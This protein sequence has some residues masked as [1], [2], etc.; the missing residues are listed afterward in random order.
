MGFRSEEEVE[1]AVRGWL[2]RTEKA[3]DPDFDMLVEADLEDR[4]KS[5]VGLPATSRGYHGVSQTSAYYALSLLYADEK[6]ER[7][8]RVLRRVLEARVLDEGSPRYGEFKLIYEALDDDVL[9]S[10]TTFFTCFALLVAAFE[11]GNRLGDDL[12]TEIREACA[13][14]PPTEYIRDLGVWYT[15]AH[16]SVYCVNLAIC[17]WL[18][19]RD[20]FEV[21]RQHFNHFYEVNMER[22]VPERLSATYYMVDFVAL[23]LILRYVDDPEMRQ[24]SRELLTLFMQE[25][26]FFRDRQ[27]IPARRTYNQNVGAAL[28]RASLSWILGLW[29]PGE[30]DEAEMGESSWLPLCDALIRDFADFDSFTIHGSRQM[31][32]LHVDG[33]GYTSYFHGDFTIGT[34]DRWPPITVGKQH[35][36]DIPVAFAGPR[37]DLVYLG[38]YSIDGND[39]EQSHPGTGLVA[40]DSWE[41]PTKVIYETVQEAN[42]ACIL[43]NVTGINVEL[44]EYGTLLRGLQYDGRLFDQRGAE[45]TVDGKLNDPWFFLRA[46]SYLAGVRVLTHFNPTGESLQSSGKGTRYRFRSNR[47][48]D[49]FVPAFRSKEA[50]DVSGDNLPCGVILVVGSSK[51]RFEAFRAACVEAKIKDEWYVDGYGAR[52]GY[53]DAERRVGIEAFG[54]SLRL[55]VDYLTGE[56]K[57]RTFTGRE[58]GVPS[59]LSAIRLGVQPWVV[60][61]CRH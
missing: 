3:F 5:R 26:F 42:V 44:K 12:V 18:K 38:H 49:V 31:R 2:G 8:S 9:D 17:E 27:P 47:G 60:G 40:T 37:S 51:W 16:L 32:G 22:G 55:S 41:S 20:R 25:L 43:M 61:N 35:E 10:N 45:R 7:A 57:E 36:S 48:L 28:H 15:N 46:D 6:T 52:R 19:D 13:L 23:G 33:N 59:E 50:I 39:I 1:K 11:Y 34:F 21:S 30:E 4:W 54:A 58:I 53:R 14:I 29:T 56:V 24:K